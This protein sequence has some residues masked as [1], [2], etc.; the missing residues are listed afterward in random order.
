MKFTKSLRTA[1]LVAAGA[2]IG[3]IALAD[4]PA[5]VSASLSGTYELTYD[6]S[7]SGSPFTNGYPATFVING[8][9]GSLCV[10]GSL[11][12]GAYLKNAGDAEVRWDESTV[13]GAV[14]YGLST[15]ADGSFNEINVYSGGT[16][17]GQFT[18]ERVSTATD[19]S[20]ALGLSANALAAIN[21]A[22][23]VFGDL[24]PFDGGSEFFEIKGYI[25]RY[26][27]DTGIYVGFKDGH[28]YV[29][30]GPFGDKII[31]QGD[32]AA[33]VL[34]LE[35]AK[36]KIEAPKGCN[37]EITGQLGCGNWDI[38]ITGTV[39]QTMMGMTL[40]LKLEDLLGALVL[41]DVPMDNPA[42][43]AEIKRIMNEYYSDIGTIE[44]L[45]VNIVTN[46]DDHV[47]LDVAFKAHIV[48]QGVTIDQV[49]DLH[50]DMTRN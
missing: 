43:E 36:L 10:N 5:D 8:A 23:E 14:S 44:D 41:E 27:G 4:V 7:Q 16:F 33:V 37:E 32:E 39:S 28:V 1:G 6:F 40:N 13:A 21:L 29:V 18:G 9:D 35:N 30:G 22:E 25:A 47:V 24:F 50:Y 20:G 48:Q 49:Y 12:T 17:L 26:Y 2:M 15:K 19:C 38:A 45:V 11:L 3:Q 46:T 34:K 42:S 31:D